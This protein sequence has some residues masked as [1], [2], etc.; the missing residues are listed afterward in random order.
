M[1]IEKYHDF[2]CCDE[3]L[4]RFLRGTTDDFK[5]PDGGDGS[6]T[7]VMRITELV[8]PLT[9]YQCDCGK[10]ATWYFTNRGTS[11]KRWLEEHKAND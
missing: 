5:V 9:S 10:S 3:H 7:L 8:L 6:V 4:I 1:K 2:A 11:V